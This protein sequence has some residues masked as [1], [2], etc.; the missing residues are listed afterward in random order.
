MKI[1][2]NIT[3]DM[4]PMPSAVTTRD[5]TVEGDPGAV[6]T[7]T[8]TNEDGHFYNFSE[9]AGVALAFSATPANLKAKT[10]NETGVY[11]GS[12]QFPAITDDDHYIITLYADGSSNTALDKS[13]SSNKIYILPRIQKYHDTTVTFAVASAGSS[14]TYTANPPASNVTFTRPSYLVKNSSREAKAISWSVA[15]G[16]SQ[17]II[18]RQPIG[19]DFQFTTTK[20]T[21]SDSSGTSIELT[22][23]SGLAVNMGVT[24]TGIAANSVIREIIPGYLNANKSYDDTNIYDIPLATATDL[25]ENEIISKSTGGTIVIN[26]SS[27]WGAAATLTFTGKGSSHSKIF[28]NTSFSIKNLALTIDP[29][30]TT[31]DAVVSN[32][33]TIPITSTNGIKAADTVLMTGIGVTDSSPHVDSVSAGVSVTVSSNQT[34]ENGQTVTFTGSSRSATIT[35]DFTVS[36]HGTDDMTLTLALDNILTVG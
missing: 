24:G 17:F 26:N 22:D 3:I 36:Q 27:T 29:V 14:G 16:S 4:S 30:V 28:N 5:F 21:Y 2:N 20:T 15:L 1:I 7:M 18:A 19:S 10:I 32:S 31:T 9:D 11:T 13:L 8:V 6:F 33:T 34:I 25:N 12:I 23:I 35:G